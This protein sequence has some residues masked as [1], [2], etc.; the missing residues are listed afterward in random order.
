MRG[1]EGVT[2]ADLERFAA[3]GRRAQTAVTEKTKPQKYRSEP[4]IVT[5]DGTLF[6]TADLITAELTASHS[7]IA[8]GTL[9]ERAAR[10]GIHGQW[11]ASMKE[12]HRYLELKALERAGE[13]RELRCQVGYDLSVLSKIDQREH[14][15][16]R[17]VC[18]FQYY[19]GL[20]LVTEDTKSKVTKTPLYRRSKKHFETQYGLR[21]LET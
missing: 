13:I 6:T 7:V 2:L 3:R 20:E 5:A 16:G 21:I 1:W 18:D 15:I 10:L 9:V 17:W 4:C 19:R 14:V 8:S 11:F 12:G